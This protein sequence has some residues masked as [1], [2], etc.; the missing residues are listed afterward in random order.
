MPVVDFIKN[1]GVSF[2]IIRNGI[3]FAPE[4][5]LTDYDKE[6]NAKCITFCRL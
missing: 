2:S 3:E 6:R 1:H 5:G 4:K